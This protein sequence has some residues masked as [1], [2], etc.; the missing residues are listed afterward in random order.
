MESLRQQEAQQ[1]LEENS[2]KH[3]MLEQWKTLDDIPLG[4]VGAK[5][6]VTFGDGHNPK[7]EAVAAVLMVT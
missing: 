5:M 1:Y 6:M 4:R 2:N 7:P 3:F